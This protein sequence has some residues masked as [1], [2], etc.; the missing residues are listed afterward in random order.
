MKKTILIIISLYLSSFCFA[1]NKIQ[2]ET[3]LN[4]KN[5]KNYIYKEHKKQLM[6][7]NKKYQEEHKN[8]NSDKFYPNSN[9]ENLVVSN[10][11]LIKK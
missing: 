11:K 9:T 6:E 5:N 2:S 1:Q 10:G 8:L 3:S 4:N 7:I